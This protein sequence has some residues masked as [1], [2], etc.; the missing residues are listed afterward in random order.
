[1][2]TGG[3]LSSSLAAGA[4]CLYAAASQMPDP[5][6]GQSWSLIG[7]LAALVLGVG[8][9]MARGILSQSKQVS[10]LEVA[11]TRLTEVLN[12]TEENDEKRGNQIISKL[13][14]MSNEFRN[15]CKAKQ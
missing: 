14:S 3:I 4:S 11:I 2:T 12:K 6:V 9:M 13:E 10:K 15:S 7:L 5:T 1:M 8:G